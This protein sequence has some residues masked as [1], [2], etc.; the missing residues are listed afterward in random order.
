[1][2]GGP[3]NLK[4]RDLTVAFGQVMAVRDVSLTVKQGE[5]VAIF[6][7][8]GSGKTTFLKTVAGLIPATR[9]RV[10]YRGEDVS[11][12]P[13][14]ERAARGMRY[15]SDRSRVAKRMTVL[16]NLEAG[17]WL[18]PPSRWNAAR[19]RVFD[20]FPVLAEKAISPAGVLSGGERQM[21]ILGRALVGEPTL[22][23]MDEPFLGLSREIR[24]R[25]LSTIEE[26]LKGRVSILFAEHDAEG[27]LRLLDRHVVF[28]NGSVVHEGTRSEILDA[29]ELVS[30]LHRHFRPE[31]PAG[32]TISDGSRRKE[33]P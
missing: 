17:A 1:M 24:D 16:E 10:S 5:A 9:G 23:L 3:A 12:L 20:L 21:L 13:A 31:N 25:L 15:V 11:G 27:A 30:L 18:L 26:T 8:N 14:H 29:K 6:G 4:V 7:A 19:D 32:E 33:A 28:R 22:L 2:V